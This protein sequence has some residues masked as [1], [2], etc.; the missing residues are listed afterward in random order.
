MNWPIKECWQRFGEIERIENP[1]FEGRRW[2]QPD[3]SCWPSLGRAGGLDWIGQH[4]KGLLGTRK[5]PQIFLRHRI[6]F[7]SWQEA[8]EIE[9]TQFTDT[10]TVTACFWLLPEISFGATFIFDNLVHIFIKN[11]CLFSKHF[12]GNWHLRDLT[13]IHWLKM[14]KLKAITDPPTLKSWNWCQLKSRIPNGVSQNL[15]NHW[16]GDT[17][18]FKLSDSKTQTRGMRAFITLVRNAVTHPEVWIWGKRRMTVEKCGALI[19]LRG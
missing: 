16:E 13:L 12:Q 11:I 9:F 14:R 1:G 19:S 4:T 10:V 7:C 2:M 5:A 6:F 15:H 3:G 8:F 17:F 18:P